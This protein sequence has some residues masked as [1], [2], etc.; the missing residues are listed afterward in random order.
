MRAT[1]V[2]TIK[3]GLISIVLTLLAAAPAAAVSSVDLQWRGNGG[4]S[5]SYNL[6]TEIVDIVLTVD[7]AANTVNG[8]FW[9][10]QYDATEL[11]V[12]GAFE[13]NP[14]DNQIG[15]G[16]AL[17]SNTVNLPGMGNQFTPVA[18]ATGTGTVGLV[19][20][21][22]VSTL[23]TGLEAGNSRTIGSVKFLITNVISDPDVDIQVVIQQ[24]GIDAISDTSG[25]RCVGALS[26]N[27]CPY[28]FNALFVPEP[29][30]ATMVVL[31]LGLGVFYNRRR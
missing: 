18:A 28:T 5:Q 31:G 15:P 3:R 30:T 9:T 20:G 27:D 17:T 22:D 23:T 6:G 8:V 12:V 19:Q 2:S 24:N 10:V 11:S 7:A 16:L 29:T 25:A 4:A 14:S 26:R 13:G 21:F 1:A